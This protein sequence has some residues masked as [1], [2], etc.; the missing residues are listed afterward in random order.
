MG[1]VGLVPTLLVQLESEFGETGLQF[2]VGG[3]HGVNFRGVAGIE[4]VENFLLECL[5]MLQLAP[6]VVVGS[7][8][9]PV[10]SR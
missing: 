4:A 9:R 6:E 1:L 10:S 2:C 5:L 3:P 7:Q 8:V